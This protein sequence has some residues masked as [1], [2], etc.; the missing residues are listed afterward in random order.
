M[1]QKKP[2]VLNMPFYLWIV[3]VYPVF[4]LYL[5]NFGMVRDLEVA[6][7]AALALSATTLAFVLTKRL[8]P[9]IHRRAAVLAIW[10]LAHSLSGHI[11]IEWVMPFSLTVWTLAL[12][13]LIA[14]VTY[15]ARR[16]IQNGRF[17][18]ATS[19]LNIIA[20]VL[21]A[22]QGAQF[23]ALIIEDLRRQSAAEAY[24]AAH[25]SR[26]QVDKALNSPDLPD[27]YYIIPDAYP[28]DAWHLEAM[29]Y[30]NSPFTEGLQAL[31]F[32]VAAHAQSNYSASKLSIP[33]TLNMRYFDSNPTEFSDADYLRLSMSSSA[34]AQ[35]LLQRGYTYIQ[36]QS[37][38]FGLSP[39]ADIYR[40]YTHPG[41]RDLPYADFA[42]SLDDQL[43]DKDSFL[44][45][46]TDTSSLRAVASQL[47]K[48]AKLLP[49]SEAEPPGF[50]KSQRFLHNLAQ[51]EDILQMPQ[52]TFTIAHLQ[53]PHRPVTFNRHCETIGY[54]NGASPEQYLDELHCINQRLLATITALVDAAPR[55]TVIILQA[56]HGS[57]Y[58]TFHHKNPDNTY[59]PAYAAYYLPPDI[60][61]DFPKPYTLVNSFP[62]LLNTLF[63]TAFELQDDRYY[64]LQT[65][66]HEPFN[67]KDVT[68]QWL[69]TTRS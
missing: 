43:P 21:L 66:Y 12:I 54:I 34:V 39:I 18:Q 9:D 60:E 3:G 65:T 30:D 1:A 32:K 17:P 50:R 63:D 27:I 28:S 58:G 16:A 40:L 19:P 20:T 61:L 67:Q 31:G 33:S 48:L 59:F 69:S 35:E 56:D 47:E 15:L 49:V 13:V 26:P 41:S 14:F 8:F 4:H 7:V 51:L 22:L 64:T 42:D 6:L 46:Y 68:Q 38:T 45:L 2:T 53:K 37:G 25:A 29:N 44:R 62:L 10:S 36:L 52:A 23:A 11:Y 55:E 5:A 57:T 24:M